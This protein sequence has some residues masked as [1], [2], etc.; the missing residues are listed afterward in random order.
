MQISNESRNNDRLITLCMVKNCKEIFIPSA[1]QYWPRFLRALASAS[2]STSWIITGRRALL[3]YENGGE[4]RC[5]NQALVTMIYTSP[6][7]FDKSRRFYHSPL[8]F[9]FLYFDSRA[10][11]S[12]IINRK[13]HHRLIHFTSH[14]SCYLWFTFG[15]RVKIALILLL[16]LEKR[17]AK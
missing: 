14:S 1:S 8:F 9:P 16:F 6:W 12:L 15:M 7:P 2:L 11:S 10:K 17:K 3:D 5:V 13:K 4:R